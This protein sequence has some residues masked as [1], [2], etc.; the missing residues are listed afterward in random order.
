MKKVTLMSFVG[1]MIFV[2]LF[3]I[4]GCNDVVP[5]TEAEFTVTINNLYIQGPPLILSAGVFYTH[6]DGFP[7]F[8]TSSKDYGQGLELLAEDGM[9]DELFNNLMNNKYVK[10]IGVFPD[11]FPGESATLKFTAKYG[12]FLNLATMFTASNDAF[13]SFDEEGFFLFEPDG[14]PVSGDVTNKIWLWDAGTE[15]NEPPFMGENQPK[16]PPMINQGEATQ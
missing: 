7:L 10:T 2:I 16:M 8:F 3:T 12:D 9:P 14:D 13:Y 4:S 1:F 6:E 15:R 11:I 5:E